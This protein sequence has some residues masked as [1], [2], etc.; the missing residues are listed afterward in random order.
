MKAHITKYQTKHPNHTI[1]VITFYNA[2]RNLLQK[3]L[4]CKVV[5]VDGCQGMEADAV[6]VSCVRSN[7]RENIGFCRNKNRLCV[8]MSR[9]K[10]CLA[11]FG[12]KQTFHKNRLWN[13]I[14]ESC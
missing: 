6:F 9:A 12:N 5:S 2:Q 11:I 13:K 8:A 10:K 14:I 4:E 1:M 3:E 7:T